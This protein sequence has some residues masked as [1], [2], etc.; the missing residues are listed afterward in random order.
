MA[1]A[2]AVN[3]ITVNKRRNGIVGE[4]TS[5]RKPPANCR[6]V[7]INHD[8]DKIEPIMRGEPPKDS[9]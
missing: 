7:M 2:T 5:Y 6:K 4:T 3:A 8:A 1:V 9:T